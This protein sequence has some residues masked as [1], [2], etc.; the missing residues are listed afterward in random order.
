MCNET[1]EIKAMGVMFQRGLKLGTR[2]VML[3]AVLDPVCQ[4][5]DPTASEAR[6]CQGRCRECG[7]TAGIRGGFEIQCPASG[8]AQPGSPGPLTRWPRYCA[9]IDRGRGP[10]SLQKQSTRSGQEEMSTTRGRRVPMTNLNY[11]FHGRQVIQSPL[12][13]CLQPRLG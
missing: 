8:V 11:K 10:I 1:P 3:P 2:K 13:S 4:V 7:L 9:F 5:Q 6:Q 12:C